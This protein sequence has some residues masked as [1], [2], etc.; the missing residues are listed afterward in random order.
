MSRRTIKNLTG[1]ALRP[2]DTTLGGA[3]VFTQ[4]GTN[5]VRPDQATCEAYGY[6]YDA[7]TSTCY[8][9]RPSLNLMKADRDFGNTL[10]GGTNTIREGVV[11][12]IVH[13][14]KNTFNGSN[15]ND[16]TIGDQNT[17]A[18]GVNNTI[19]IG[20][21]ANVTTSN[22][23]YIGANQPSDNLGERQT[24][25]L[26]YAGTTTSSSWQS[27]SIN[28]ESGV[29]F[30]LPN[31]AIIYYHA[32]TIGVRT[33]GSS[34]S[35]NPGD[36]FSA[37]ERG[38]MI[39]KSG[40]SSNSREKDTIKT[41]GTVTGWNVRSSTVDNSLRFEVKGATDMTLQWNLSVRITMI[42]TNVSL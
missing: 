16:V 23:L 41:S 25:L 13:G 6:E 8:A 20:E 5:P 9:F 28:N 3:V 33:A 10:R 7:T 39:N 12:N 42:Q 30:V 27:C 38:V 24:V 21:L 36:Y 26:S 4:D 22:S 37:V 17:I 11:T 35:G 1:Q 14:G 32:D 31:N 29:K 19:T 18:S 40:T 34:G 15:R 2:L